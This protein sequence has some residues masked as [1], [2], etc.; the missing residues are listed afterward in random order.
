[1]T[2]N[3]LMICVLA[4]AALVAPSV[5]QGQDSQPSGFSTAMRYDGQGRIVGIIAPDHVGASA[6]EGYPASRT[7]Y[8]ANG[9]VVRK[10]EGT[11]AGWQPSNVAPVN[12]PGFLIRAVEHF[13]YDTRG[14]LVRSWTTDAGGAVLQLAQ[15]NYD[16]AS[17][18]ACS[19]VRMN[20]GAFHDAPSF[21]AIP[22]N[23]CVPQATGAQGP[24]RIT[25]NVYNAAGEIVQVRKAVGTP[26]E[27][28]YVSYTYTENG[29][30]AGVVDANGNPAVFQYDGYDRLVAH[31]FPSSNGTG[32]NW[33][34]YEQYGYDLAGN[35][36][37]LRKRDEQV[38]TYTYDALNRVTLK[39]VPGTAA[40][41][42][43]GYD[44]R[45]LQTFA[46][47]GGPGG[48]GISNSY[49]G[50]GR[51]ISSTSNL[52]SN[53]RTLGYA[54]NAASNR[55]SITHP[56]GVW[57]G[58]SYDSPGRFSE[59]YTASGAP[60]VK[61][62]YDN[63]G[64]PNRLYRWTQETW[65]ANT[66]IN[67]DAISRPAWHENAFMN[68]V[69]DI[70]TSFAYNPA[71]QITS[72]LSNTSAY[73]FDR[74]ENG[75]RRYAVNGLN[76]YA[77]VSSA[78]YGYDANGNLTS[79]GLNTYGYDI[80]NR[81]VSVRGE[82]I[83]DLSYDPLGR[84]RKVQSA[85]MGATQFLYDGDALVAEYDESGTL[86]KRYVH[87]QGADTPQVWFEG[88]GTDAA[89]RRYLFTNHQG[90][91]TAIAD[92]NG[93]TMK[94][95]RYD[96]YGVPGQK[97]H[98][99]FQYTGQAWLEELGMYHYK[100]RVYSP[101]LGRF[102]QTDPI[103]YE[104]QVNLYAY[105]GNDPVNAVDPSGKDTVVTLEGYPLGTYPIV[106]GTF[107]HSYVR[108]TDTI[109][110][111]SYT[112][113]GGPSAEIGTSAAVSNSAANDSRRRT[114]TL[115]AR[116]DPASRNP[117]TERGGY[118]DQAGGAETIRSA[119]LG[120]RPIGSVVKTLEGVRDSVNGQQAPYR[121]Q[122]HNSNTAAGA[123]FTSATGQ[124]VTA[125]SKYPGI[126]NPL[127]PEVSQ[128]TVYDRCM[129]H[130]GSC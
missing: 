115:T 107:G 28:A 122:S 119:N 50:F 25:K 56:D 4:S 63:A 92:G 113:R 46:R 15:A 65:G 89:S 95:N 109:T 7:F 40:D 123:A 72:I 125:T 39:D 70:R 27:Q 103:G 94:V 73:A 9:L 106:G 66:N 58:S 129:G 111:E 126:A 118:A 80:E 57:F 23:A 77:S 85:T 3:P 42:Y 101:L 82:R 36:T 93:N 121:A 32:V 114:V 78:P 48:E 117:D 81:L 52:E 67:L 75:E 99:R 104:D 55:T 105:V 47:F 14:R 100:A 5:A 44:L 34:D 79:D 21:S 19:T 13:A 59:S 41:V 71:G 128:K 124:A 53:V 20:A 91:V 62:Q 16:R 35:R 76:Q 17:R 31:Y 120:D 11:L 61:Q 86:L 24:D 84:L 116:V 68:G 12:W 2:R 8:D 1:M 127:K 45:G 60:L 51:L 90:S 102:L 98:G 88:P 54:Y 97:S 108:V 6:A 29:K 83:V 26:L 38:I 30:Q 112:F 96:E 49:D 18:P 33:N 110:G 43:F 130:P 22:A 10:E 37:G 64:R 87:G 74:Y 69:D